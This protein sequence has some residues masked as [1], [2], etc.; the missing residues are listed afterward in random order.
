M[1]EDESLPVI[2]TQIEMP[3]NKKLIIALPANKKYRK[4]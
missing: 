4:F 1:E 3:V 2:V